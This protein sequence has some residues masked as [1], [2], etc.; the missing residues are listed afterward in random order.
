[1][2]TGKGKGDAAP[3]DKRSAA[4][5][6]I[7]G[8]PS[9]GKT[10]PAPVQQA[11]HAPYGG[12]PA[13]SA[14]PY[15]GPATGP[16]PPHYPPGVDRSRAYSHPAPP[17]GA[18]MHP[19]VQRHASLGY[20]PRAY[21]SPLSS[22]MSSGGYYAPQQPRPPAPRPEA[23][24]PAALVASPPTWTREM[25]GTPSGSEYVPA[26]YGVESD[27]YATPGMAEPAPRPHPLHAARRFPSRNALRQA[28]MPVPAAS[29][30]SSVDAQP[31][32]RRATSGTAIPPPFSETD[33]G[34]TDLPLDPSS[35][36]DDE[37]SLYGDRRSIASQSTNDGEGR[38]LYGHFESMPEP[39]RPSRISVPGM[40]PFLGEQVVPATST[41]PPS[42]T[43][44]IYLGS[45]ARC[46][47]SISLR[48]DSRSSQHAPAVLTGTPTP[49]PLS[50][51]AQALVPPR[52]GSMVYPA[53]LSR[54]AD[55]FAHIITIGEC[56]KDGLTYAD[57][58]TGRE[59]VDKLA[60]IVK[61]SDRNLALLL[62][63]ALD[64]QKFFH[65]VTYD[66]RLRDSVH[67]LY[68]FRDPR[69]T[70][71]ASMNHA[72]EQASSAGDST[73]NASAPRTPRRSLGSAAD[74]FSRDSSVFTGA[75]GA[76]RTPG[77]TPPASMTD[78]SNVTR[79]LSQLSTQSE[80]ES[81]HEVYTDAKPAASADNDGSRDEESYPVGIFTLLTECYSP[82]C[83][84]EHLCYSIACPRRLEQQA[85]RNPQAGRL[86]RS[87]SQE[88]LSEGPAV[89]S[90]WTDSV[91]K[92]VRESVPE[93]E[94]K[95][96]EVIFEV[97]ST[98]RAFVQD[99]EYLR[100]FW[101]TPLRTLS[102]IPE[103]RRE[104]FV[105]LV[106]GNVTEILAVNARVA[107]QLARRQ[108]Q[109][110]V[111]EQIGDIY[112]NMLPQF[113][114]FVRY[115]ANQLF[116][117]VEFEREKAANPRFAEFAARTERL[118]ESRK[119]EL[120]GFL[121]K[122]T[123]RLARYPLLFGQVLKYTDE[124]M[125][126]STLLP[127][128][129]Q[130]IKRLLARVNEASGRSE[131]R[132]QIGMLNQQLVFRPGELVDLRLNES[133]RELVFKGA[134]KKRSSQSD[135][136]E[137]Q[138]YLFDHALLMVKHKVVHKNE[139]FK[140]YRK[141]IPL[142]L[143]LVTVYD[144]VPTGKGH[145]TRIKSIMSRTTVGKRTSGGFITGA[146]PKQDAKTG[147]AI[148][149][150]YLGKKGYSI[151]L[152]ANTFMARAKWFEHIEA[153]QDILRNRSN[154]FDIITLTDT[155]FDEP[156]NHVTC[157]VPFDFG[158]RIIY[159]K[160]D[161]VYLGELQEHARPPVKVL[162]LT[163]VTQVDVLEEYQILIVLA[164]QAVHTF[165]LDALDASDPLASLK[166]GRRISSHTSFFRAGVCLGRTLVC[167]V[168]SGPVSSTIKT[169]EPIEQNVRNKKQPTF[170][171]LL[172][173]GQDTLRVFKEF[174]IP[175][176][177]SSIHFLKSKLCIG[178]TKGFEVVDLETLDTQGLLDPADTSL[179]FVQRRENLKPIAIYRIDG[180]FLL[181]YNEFAFYVNKNGWRARRNW[182]VNWEGNPTAFALFHPYVLAFEP[183]FVE[184]R[185]VETGALHQ[186]ITGY[187]LRCLFA[188][189]PPA[190]SGSRYH[191]QR[192]YNS[193]SSTPQLR[194]THGS[195]HFV[196]GS[197]T[198][199]HTPLHAP[200]PS[201][202]VPT[203]IPQRSFSA[204]APPGS[205]VSMSASP[206]V[207][208]SPY[209]R[210]PNPPGASAGSPYSMHELGSTSSL[211]SPQG[212]PPSVYGFQPQR[213]ATMPTHNPMMESV[214]A[215]RTQIVFAG[216][217]Y[218]FCVRL[219]ARNQ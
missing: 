23:Y 213:A 162:P 92:D 40:T 102:I 210:T 149:F 114:P 79:R 201:R 154:V 108:K 51:P 87:N 147:F 153:R 166:R 124:D 141:P 9:S 120:N 202:G 30:S 29:S 47:E 54:V 158:R 218:T 151:T 88:S 82:T 62:G 133:Q 178:T 22:E 89:G 118:P 177:S 46:S 131:N 32:A 135:S 7:F 127:R 1:M 174:Y 66:H 137:L 195:G 110:P 59:A 207:P 130:L 49:V 209:A 42:P 52:R 72:G 115:G 64:A 12:M 80:H 70:A 41:A 217:S 190:S 2:A 199:S 145:S 6:D 31:E 144:D 56:T 38:T 132:Y 160:D 4:F 36:L 18:H 205:P 35:V 123:T 140:V 146:P 45:D 194:H 167:V 71:I 156:T 215:S 138:V 96:Q 176:E 48:R 187:N 44:P 155:P 188:D 159:G 157:A 198:S 203:N 98:E 67:E 180:D 15:P 109:Q 55:A 169:L 165:T 212:A 63:R 152:W 50:T 117:K 121:T 197:P 28:S 129:I 148:T 113:E 104:E 8:R 26:S 106:F 211:Q 77:T 182:I 163:G 175:T 86:E 57:A 143:L 61:T 191:P 68:Q 19:D 76:T 85:R 5:Q 93:R 34:P 204:F 172:Q 185:H 73:A 13:G 196:V 101:M 90:L 139:V 125:A 168:K 27:S 39:P 128:A 84:R 183:S 25:P 112:L 216:D 75:T 78:M 21:P 14:R 20:P 111:I 94:R 214:V 58:F 186:V 37:L 219:H 206:P 105:R 3:V 193:G 43:T 171:K 60:A 192:A 173:G 200:A 122:P 16:Y 65:D 134:L 170:R 189:M 181:C 161:G 24:A 208:G 116:G 11:V 136:G 53:L 184:V 100:D 74:S 69:V 91:S 83:S 179:D 164:E 150:T 99:L 81:L 107:E 126:D 103:F 95:R 142:E 10:K 17:G 33:V 97:I 119:L